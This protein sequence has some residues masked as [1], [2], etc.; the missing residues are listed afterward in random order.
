MSACPRCNR[1]HSGLCGIPAGVTLGFGARIS[2]VGIGG[3]RQKRLGTK[4]DHGKPKAAR[5]DT[6]VLEEMLAAGRKQYEKV[7][8]ML[9][10]IPSEMLEYTELLDREGKLTH[11]IKQIEG[12][13]AAARGVK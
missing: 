13:I 2:G 9:K 4:V 10:L 7:L 11:L 1:T 3:V 6:V 8:E 5:I 12:Q